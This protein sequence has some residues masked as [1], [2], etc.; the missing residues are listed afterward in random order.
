MASPHALL[1]DGI[2]ADLAVV[3]RVA[4]VGTDGVEQRQRTAA[5]AD[6]EPEVA[7]ELGDVAGHATMV[8]CVDLLARELERRRL[9]R[10]ARLL[11]ADAELVED[12][13]LPGASLVLHVH[14]GVE[15]HERAVLELAERVDLGQRHV[16]LQ[17][18]PR[19]PA[20][21][22]RQAV[23]RRAADAERGDQLLGLPVRERTD[24]GEVRAGDVIGMLL[25]DLLD[26]DP[27]HVGEQHH[28]ALANPVPD[29]AGVVLVLDRRP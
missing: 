1:T 21:D 25:G 12:R 17:E 2:A 14:V 28:R 8:L 23:E 16:V 3:R 29:D 5:G 9:A 4:A 10:L 27:A 7:V 22:R 15:R 11:V 6:H 26:V 19:E 24:R 18:Q 13:L 20:E